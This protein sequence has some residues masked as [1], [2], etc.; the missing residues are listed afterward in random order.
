MAKRHESAGRHNP[1]GRTNL[2]PRHFDI[3]RQIRDGASS[4][5]EIA[6]NLGIATDTLQVHL[7]D[8]GAGLRRRLGLPGGRYPLQVLL[9]K[10][11]ELNINLDQESKQE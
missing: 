3:L 1:I 7:Y 11:K 10:A 9:D 8:E 6:Q 5:A 4:V 2:T